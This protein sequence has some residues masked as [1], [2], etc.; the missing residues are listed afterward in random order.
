MLLELMVAL[1]VVGLLAAIALPTY[2]A[3]IER[4][5]VGEAG[6]ELM[7]ISVAIERYRTMRFEVPETLAELGLDAKLLEDPWGRQYQ[8]L[9]FNSSI[10][11]IK[12]KIR[13]DHNL[14]PLNSEFDLYSLGE[15]GQSQSPLT[16]KASR[17][18]VIWA[19]DGGFVGLAEDY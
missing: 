1:A 15:D 17:D 10:P 18:D 13:K 3:I 2:A 14:H 9:S 16:A 8:F 5:K 19:R 12:G 7:E 6:R 11:G 4:Q